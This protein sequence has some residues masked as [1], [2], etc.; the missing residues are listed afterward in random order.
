MKRILLASVFALTPL[1]GATVANAGPLPFFNGQL[2]FTGTGEYTPTNII[3]T[4]PAGE[5]DQANVAANTATG[6]FVSAFSAGCNYCVK[7]ASFP[8]SYSNNPDLGLTAYSVTLN[9][10]TNSFVVNNF[11]YTESPS[12]FFLTAYGYS[13]LTGYA[14]S[15]GL[16]TLTSQMGGTTSVNVSFSSTVAVPEPGSLILLGTGLLGLGLILRRK[17]ASSRNV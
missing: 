13:T 7:V 16:L 9:G 11:S 17:K 12:S 10:V 2:S 4:A 1:L 3:F 8:L 15:P 5:T 14:D 6:S